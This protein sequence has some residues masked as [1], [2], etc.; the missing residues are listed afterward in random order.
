VNVPAP[1]TNHTAVWTG[2]EMIVW[3]GMAVNSDLRPFLDTGGRYDPSLDVWAPTSTGA[4]L[5]A[6]RAYHT[7]VWTGREMIVWGG[8]SGRYP[9]VFDSGGRYCVFSDQPPIANAGPDQTIECTGELRASA[10][11]DGSAST[12]PDSTAGTN[13][14]IATFAWSEGETPLASGMIVSV[15]FPLGT[16]TVTLT[17]TDRAGATASDNTIVTVQDTTPPLITCPTSITAECQSAGQ[18]YVALSPATASDT[19]YGSATITNSQSPN[20]ADA[21]GMYPLGTSVVTFTATDGSGN[22]TRCQAIV[23]VRDTMPPVVTAVASP[24]VLWPP[25]HKLSTVNPTVVATDT[26]DPSPSIV[27][28]SIVSSEPDDA[29]GDGDGGTTGDIQDASIGTPDFQVLLRAE[30]DGNGPGRT[31]T[32]AYRAVDHSGNT[33]GASAQVA[34]PHDMSQGVEPLDFV[35]EDARSTTLIWGPVEGARHYDVIRGDLANL[36]ID[37]SRIDLGQVVC[38]AQDTTAT[39]TIGHEDT[40]IPEPGQVFFYAVQYNDGREDSSYG[41][42]SA[43]RARVVGP[44]RGD[45]S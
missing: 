12:D 29:V 5:P 4:D 31:Y 11:L 35:M 42:E 9:R 17:V 15:P 39:T 21:S 16:H 27:L 28:A 43:G 33:A 23:T 37:G 1:R 30:R 41:S 6:A 44:N 2:R 18:A 8:A 24:S 14:D 7:A 25:N 20:G 36:S 10:V 45:C 19:C 34:V 22:Q 26:C 40:A 38:I 32:I 13:D 3:G